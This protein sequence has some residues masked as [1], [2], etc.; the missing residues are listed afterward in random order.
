MA[1]HSEVP[2][3][4]ALTFTTYAL[5]SICL[6]IAWH[7]RIPSGL[8]VGNAIA[9]VIGTGL[10]ILVLSRQRALLFRRWRQDLPWGLLLGGVLLGISHLGTRVVLRP[11]PFVN[12]ELDRLYG[13]LNTPPGPF[14][15]SPLL[16]L[17]DIAEELVFRGAVTT[18]LERRYKP[19][20]VT[21]LSTLLYVFPMLLSGSW[22]L[23]VLGLTMGCVWTIARQRSQG[24]VIPLV[25]HAVFSL[26][27]FVWLPA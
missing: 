26:A 1:E 18:W 13:L 21:L 20:T 23:P 12:T 5:T 19:L 2:F 3:D 9:G 17:V 10:G 11:I 7:W 14:L 8:W 6:T 15:C 22:L 24:L 27:L 4:S 25:S 16:L